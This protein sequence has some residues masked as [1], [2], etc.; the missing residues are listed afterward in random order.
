MRRFLLA[1]F[2]ALALPVAAMAQAPPS[3]PDVPDGAP[4]RSGSDSNATVSIRDFLSSRIDH[5]RVEFLGLMDERDRRYAQRFDAQQEAVGAALQ[6]AKEAVAN[7]LSAAK[8]AVIKAE[9]AVEKRFESVNEFRQ[10]L[11]DQSLT[12]MNKDAAEIRFKGLE[13]KIDEVAKRLDAIR[14]QE[15]GAGSL[16]GILLGIAGLIG[17]IFGVLA[18]A[19]NRPASK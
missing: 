8:E 3:E 19:R 17:V 7:A 18:F 2:L 14:S 5:L 6:S 10:T 4:Y 16:W 11:T 9:T 15:V 13:G 12:F 1:A